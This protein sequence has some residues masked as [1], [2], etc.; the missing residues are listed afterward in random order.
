LAWAKRTKIRGG[1]NTYS[2]ACGEELISRFGYGKAMP[3]TATYEDIKTYQHHVEKNIELSSPKNFIGKS[4]SDLDLI[5]RFGVQLIAIKELVPK[6]ARM[7]R[8]ILYLIFR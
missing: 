1:E 4:K 6:K 2:P 3:P 8:V 7:K 5:N